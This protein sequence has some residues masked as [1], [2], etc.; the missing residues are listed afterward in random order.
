MEE[1][2]FLCGQK[3]YIVLD[4]QYHINITADDIIGVAGKAFRIIESMYVED[5]QEYEYL[6]DGITP[7]IPQHCIRKEIQ[8]LTVAPN[9]AIRALEE[10]I[11]KAIMRNDKETFKELSKKY[12]LLKADYL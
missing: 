7:W 9:Y 10:E 6:L 5:I 11:D 4:P 2:K 1:K 12:A 3:V 8:I